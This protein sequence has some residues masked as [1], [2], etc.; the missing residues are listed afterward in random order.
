MDDACWSAAPERQEEVKH[1][2]ELCGQQKDCAVGC[3]Y[4]EMLQ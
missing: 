2:R 1:E 4:V 3:E